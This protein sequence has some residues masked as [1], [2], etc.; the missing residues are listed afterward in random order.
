MIAY[1]DLARTNAPYMEAMR[2]SFDDTLA[3]GWYVMGQ[4]VSR[5]EQDFAR[6][7]GVAHCIGTGN[8]L[9]AIE[10]CLRAFG[11]KPGSEVIV[12]ANTYIAT[13]LAVLRSGLVPILVEPDPVTCNLDPGR[14]EAAI[15]PRC[16]AILPVHMY[17]KTC[18]MGPIL[19][20]ARTH[21]LKIIEDAAQAHGARYRQAKAGAM[22]DCNAFSFYPTKNLG[23]LGDGGAV[24]TNDPDLAKRI[25]RLRN[26]GSSIKYQFDEIGC[27]SRLDEIQAGFLGVKLAYLDEINQHKRELAQAY[28]RLL[29]DTFIKPVVEADHFDVYH[30]FNIRHERRDALRDWLRERGIGTDIHYPIAPH[31]QPALRHLFEGAEFP[32]SDSI[33]ATTLSLPIA[34][35][36]TIQDI[37]RVAQAIVDFRP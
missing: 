19:G 3:S 13:I 21:G 16:V 10:L 1:E 12:P 9:D 36:H 18:R 25:A 15:T 8:G 2:K 32:I 20:I 4:N 30:I 33:H 27:N 7:C 6:Y 37:E 14:I 31:R 29:P 5:F 11:F 17:G 24:T 34:R 35:F 28:L 22:G 26:Y 23:A